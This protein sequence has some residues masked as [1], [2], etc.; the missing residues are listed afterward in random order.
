MEY[1]G[2]GDLM[3]H[4][5]TVGKFDEARSRYVCDAVLMLITQQKYIIGPDWFSGLAGEPIK[6]AVDSIKF[7]HSLVMRR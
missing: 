5:Q 1:L 4:I 7:L 6:T 2:G 3:F